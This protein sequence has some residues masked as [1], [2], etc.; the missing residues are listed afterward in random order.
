MS[1]TY[2][3]KSKVPY[4]VA[5][6]T[7]E[8]LVKALPD[9]LIVGSLRRGCAVVGDVD[10]LTTSTVALGLL[11]MLVDEVFVQGVAKVSGRKGEIQVDLNFTTVEAM[12]SAL[13]HHTGSA[14]FNVFTR[15]RARRQGFSLSQHGMFKGDQLVASGTEEEILGLLDM[16]KYLDPV[17]RSR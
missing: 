10:L 8:E 3:L 17:T 4:E 15:S 9:T 2:S 1:K 5:Q 12:G 14:Q 6:G 11:P 13:L 16:L 7:A